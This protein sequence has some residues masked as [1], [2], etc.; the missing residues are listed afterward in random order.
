MFK[1]QDQ[2]L[3][4]LSRPCALYHWD[5]SILQSFHRFICCKNIKFMDFQDKSDL[6]LTI[7]PWRAIILDYKSGA[8]VINIWWNGVPGCTIYVPI[9]CRSSSLFLGDLIISPDINQFNTRFVMINLLL[10]SYGILSKFQRTWVEHKYT[11]LPSFI[12]I[13]HQIR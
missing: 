5:A 3:P 10:S 11:C 6:D 13:D 4:N 7:W 8:E 2:V 1:K 12:S 9:Y